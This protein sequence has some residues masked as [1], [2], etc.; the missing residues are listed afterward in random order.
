MSALFDE[1][2]GL[3]I[4]LAIAAAGLGIGL[5]PQLM[6]GYAPRPADGRQYAAWRR[7]RRRL[8]AGFV[9]VGMLTALLDLL[10]RPAA[11]ARALCVG[12]AFVGV[13]LVAGTAARAAGQREKEGE[14]PT[15]RP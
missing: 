12:V 6:A 2:A 14:N 3:C 7:M 11:A 15:I 13:L 10:V 4:G 1:H 8:F 9:G 5:F